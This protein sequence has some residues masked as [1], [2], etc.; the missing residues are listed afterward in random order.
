MLSKSSFNSA[1]SVMDIPIQD[2]KLISVSTSASESISDPAIGSSRASRKRRSDEKEE[3]KSTQ[4]KQKKYSQKESKD[5][6]LFPATKKQVDPLVELCLQMTN[7][8]EQSDKNRLLRD[9][10]MI[11][12]LQEITYLQS[13]L[14]H[15]FQKGQSPLQET[16]KITIEGLN[17]LITDKTTHDTIRE[18]L[19]LSYTV[20]DSQRKAIDERTDQIKKLCCLRDEKDE[21]TID[22]ITPILN[23]F[24]KLMNE[25]L[26]NQLVR[27]FKTIAE[28]QKIIQM[29]IQIL[30]DLKEEPH[31]VITTITQE[32]MQE[33][34]SESTQDDILKGLKLSN[35]II[36]NQDN[37]INHNLIKI[38]NLIENKLKTYKH[39]QA[40]SNSFMSR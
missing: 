1:F 21:K 7:L 23:Q 26:R 35:E 37:D 33:L 18:M 12:E 4:K 29:Q 9:H 8:N 22:S 34:T 2:S 6:R 31:R 24:F 38:D 40:S 3:S 16:Q 19:E 20:I 39:R 36:K 11:I 17:V 13:H 10:E 28:R 32:D 5:W 25:I 27:N 14:L 30:H 15:N